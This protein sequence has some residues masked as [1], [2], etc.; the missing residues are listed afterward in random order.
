MKRF[1]YGVADLNER[2]YGE[3][4]C[5]LLTNGLGGYSSATIL[6]S[7]TRGDHS[8][9]T[10]ALDAPDERYNLVSC[11]E[12]VVVIDGKE[13][14]LTSQVYMG[15]ESDRDG[16]RYLVQF[17]QEYLPQWIY[18]IDGVEIEK[19]IVMEY[20]ENTVGV[21]YKIINP[22][23]QEVEIRVSPMCSF[24]K[25][26]EATLD[27]CEMAVLDDKVSA[28]GIDMYIKSNADEVAVLSKRD[29][30]NYYFE[31][32][33]RD[34]RGFNAVAQKTSE[35][36][37]RGNADFDAEIIFTTEVSGAKSVKIMMLDEINRQKGLVELSGVKSDMGKCLVRACDQFVVRR[38]SVDGMTIIAGYPFFLDWGRDTMYALEGCVIETNRF[39]EAKG[40][41]ATFS[42]YL[43]KG[44]LPNLFPEGNKDPMYN[45][46]D[47]SLLFVQAIYIYYKKSKDATFI[48]E[49]YP[50][51]EQ[52]IAYYKNGTDYDIKMDDDGLIQAGSGL[53]QL[54]W[55]DVRY[56]DILPTK[57]H[58]KPVEINAYWYNALCII[59]EFAELLGEKCE[60][61]KKLSKLVKESFIEKFWN[62]ELQCLKDVVSGESYDN[63]VRPNQIWAVSV[64]FSPLDEDKAKKVVDK[65]YREL[66]TPYGLRSLA[67]WDE[68]FKGEYSG[69]LKKRDLSYHQG[70]VWNFPLGSYFRAYLK[71]NNYSAKAVGTVKKQLGYLET[72]LSEGCVGQ[73]A[74]IYDGLFP[75][76][77]RGCYAQAWSVGE[78][79]KIVKEVEDEILY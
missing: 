54:T 39:D 37:Y 31:Y 78:I 33:E 8:L 6:Q 19:N 21:L 47:A 73:L 7:L 15:D 36:R 48:K 20:G 30:A 67:K 45:T 27:S 66:Y 24:S 9:F 51:I 5:Y 17:S 79:L 71:V 50:A 42:K 75:Y 2:K 77:S 72:G 35:Y 32:D 11:L 64:P 56:E 62:E 3:K 43:R 59:C 26:G 52:V 13:Y 38:K 23:N 53:Y 14:E 49:V 25:R 16:H 60:E 40:I 46:V 68:E 10:C 44:L 74:E 58:G 69:S 28:A 41:L 34:G 1:K 65:V 61:Y 4:R 22:L 76:E 57:R 70:T 63:Q 29:I 12:E 55:M 18:N